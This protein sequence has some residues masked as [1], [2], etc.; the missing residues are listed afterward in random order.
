[1]SGQVTLN[2]LRTAWREE[3]AWEGGARRHALLSVFKVFDQNGDGHINKLE[4]ATWARA[5]RTAG[6]KSGVWTDELNRRCFAEIDGN[7]DG[8]VNK[9]EF[10]A[11][12]KAQLP[13]E[14]NAFEAT[15]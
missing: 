8:R 9:E 7:K 5:R 10:I 14:S 2:E 12:F 3:A 6:Q 13:R 11:H 1:M 4:L 15:I